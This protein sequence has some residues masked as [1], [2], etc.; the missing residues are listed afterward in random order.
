MFETTT[1]ITNIPSKM[2]LPE[3]AASFQRSKNPPKAAGFEEN[4]VE[5]T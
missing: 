3:S 5:M 1:W 4:F 2:L